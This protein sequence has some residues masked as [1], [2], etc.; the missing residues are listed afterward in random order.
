ME[1][2]LALENFKAFKCKCNLCRHTCCGLWKIN[3]NKEDYLR[4]TSLGD[5]CNH[6]VCEEYQTP[7]R[8]AHIALDE[9]GMCPKLKDGMCS[10]QQKYGIKAL[11]TICMEYPRLVRY[12]RGPEVALSTSCEAVVEG[13]MLDRPIA[14][15]RLCKNVL[16]GNPYTK[17]QHFING[18]AIRLSLIDTLKENPSIEG[19]HKMEE[20]LGL[21]IGLKLDKRFF[22][23][24]KSIY[25][26]YFKNRAIHTGY[27]DIMD[28]VIYE[29][30][31][32]VMNYNIINILI[33]HMFYMNFPYC[34]NNDH[35]EDN[36]IGL[37]TIYGLLQI[38]FNVLEGEELIDYI[39]FIFREL[40]HSAFYDRIGNLYKEL[41]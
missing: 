40:E 15:E 32:P 7:K 30:L 24:I 1:K 12:I 10:I 38:L 20:I 33:N 22:I 28:K 9:N 31:V 3:V 21:N 35:I 14:F 4:I 34:N 39:A 17:N 6:F 13:L 2:V 19:L 25:N 8:Y 29:N 18:N 37:Y 27:I 11:T 23:F 41:I 26:E 5:D 36:M 16:L